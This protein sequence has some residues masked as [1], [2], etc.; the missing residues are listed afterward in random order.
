MTKPTPTQNLM[1]MLNLTPAEPVGGD[2]A[3]TA[4]TLTRE[5]PRTYGGQVLAQAIM[6]ADNTVTDKVLHSIHAYFL[7][8]GDITKELIF[9]SQ[10]LNNGRSF[11]TRRVQAL[12][13]DIPIFSAI[14]SFQKP[15]R[16]PEHTAVEMPQ[17]PEPEGLPSVSDY[18]GE[19]AHPVAQAVAWER[20]IDMR[21]VDAPL[22]TQP[23]ASSTQP[24]A[25]V[26][27]KTFD[28]LVHADGSEASE[29]EHRA[30]IAYASDYLPLEPA[31]RRHGKFWLEPGLK[32]ASLDHAMWFHRSARA[33]EWLLYVLD[34]PSAQG[35]RMLA[36]GSIFNRSGELVATVAQEMMFRLPEYR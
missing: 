35:G 30:A 33:D 14:A 16:G 5:T 25:C 15:G 21:H 31:L 1:T 23:D 4:V 11:A 24:R 6:A 32:S 27:F 2:D 17:V 19:V 3:F 10:Q 36:Q 22:Y 12:Q 28:R 13:D 9:T 20:P 7:H 18:I 8:P 26:W 29:A 34:S